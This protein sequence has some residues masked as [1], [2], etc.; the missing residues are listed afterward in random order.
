MKKNQWIAVLLSL[1]ISLGIFLSLGLIFLPIALNSP[2]SFVVEEESDIP[3]APR[4]QNSGVLYLSDDGS[5]LLI[6]LN[7]DAKTAAV[8]LFLSD[9]EK[10]A[11]GSGFEINYIIRGSDLFLCEFCDRLGGVDIVENGVERRFSGAALKQKLKNSSTLFEKAEISEG[12]FKVFSKI[13]LSLEDFQ[14]IIEN[15][16]TNLNFPV[17]FSWKDVLKDTLSNYVFENGF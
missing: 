5:G 1:C 7:F 4:F 17:C 12:F 15:T 16:K 10:A 13:G 11:L 8:N 3:Y 6:F 9:A 2:S 14:F